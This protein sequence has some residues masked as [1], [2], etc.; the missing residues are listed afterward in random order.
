M[1]QGED[2]MLMLSPTYSFFAEAAHR[3]TRIAGVADAT[4]HGDV[5]LAERHA[6]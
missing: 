2:L 1:Q 5:T 6:R 4:A 3:S